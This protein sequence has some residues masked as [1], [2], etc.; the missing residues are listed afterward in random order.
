MLP[1]ALD[2]IAFTPIGALS[3]LLDI[4]YSSSRLPLTSGNAATVGGADLMLSWN[5]R[6]IVNFARMCGYNSVNIL[7]GYRP[8]TI[9]SPKEVCDED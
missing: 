8:L 6:H 3:K 7:R 9:L 2:G 4:W 5:F 1:A